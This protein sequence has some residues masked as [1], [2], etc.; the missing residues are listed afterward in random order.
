MIWC[1]CVIDNSIEWPV[2]LDT[3]TDSFVY[4]CPLVGSITRNNTLISLNSDDRLVCISNVKKICNYA[5]HMC[6]NIEYVCISG[7]VEEVMEDAFIDSNIKVVIFFG[8]KTFWKAKAYRN[9]PIHL[10]VFLD[11]SLYIVL[12]QMRCLKICI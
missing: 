10:L 4:N 7:D 11:R 3:T 6:K 9:Q 1:F 8:M 12:D 2:N 5:F